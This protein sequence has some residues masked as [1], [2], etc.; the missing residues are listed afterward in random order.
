MTASFAWTRRAAAA[1]LFVGN[2]SLLITDSVES[3]YALTAKEMVLSGDW[4]SPQIYG[5]YWYDKPIFFY[6]LTALAYKMFGFTEFAS[7]FFPALFGLGSVALLAWGG[8]KLENARSGFFSALVLLSSVE[9]FLISKSVITDAVLFFFFSATLL[10]FYLGYCD[11]RARYWYIMYAAAGFA[12]LTKGPIGVLLPGLIITLFLLWQRDWRVLKRMHLVSGI[13]LCAVVSV[14]WYAVMYSL[15]GSDFINTFFGTHN[16]LRATVYEHPR[17]DV[18]Y[19]YTLVNLLALFPWS[20][21]IPWAAYKWWRQGQRS[22]EEQQKFLLL[23][24]LVVFIFFQCMATKY[25]TY[26]YP[27]LFPASLLLGSM[28]AKYT[29]CAD[30]G[31]MFF[32]G[33][34]LAVLLGGAWF[35]VSNKIIAS[36]LL[37]LLP[38]A[39]IVGVMLDYIL[40]FVTSERVCSIAVMSAVFYIAL[41][42]SLAIPFSE[43]R[44]AKNLGEMLTENDVH[45]V[46]LYG[47]YPTSAVFYSSSKIVKL[48]HEREVAGYVP[49]DF[50]W[51]SKNVMPYAT[52]EQNPYRIVVV[53]SKSYDK[54]ISQ[55]NDEWQVIDADKSW[56]VLMA[57]KAKTI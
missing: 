31:Y 46:G 5:H 18:F 15:H 43:Q 16:F 25:I 20:G 35:A 29:D 28:L 47:K 24:A 34:G 13:L 17:D 21:L 49:K 50:S 19:Y 26:T 22:L 23:W 10:F 7:R 44:S 30:G 36:E 53:T 9:F 48:M 11:G 6:W 4:L 33:G 12:V 52:L 3:N 37:F 56:I 51:T 2:G 40:R 1:L 39:L 45:E 38:L 42:F 54:F 27:L 55:Q 57:K 41:I 14:P 32:V 8:S